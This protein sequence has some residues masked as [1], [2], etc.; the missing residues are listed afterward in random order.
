[1]E[2]IRE[3]YYM[4]EFKLISKLGIFIFIFSILTANL[5]RI[6]KKITDDPIFKNQLIQ[7]ESRYKSINKILIYGSS[8][9]LMG[10]SAETIEKNINIKSFNIS[11]TGFGGQTD[12]ALSSITSRSNLGDIILV[13]DR[14]YRT[15]I[16]KKSIIGNISIIP[17]LKIL[18]FPPLFK[19]N[20]HG[21]LEIYPEQPFMPIKNNLAPNYDENLIVEKMILQINIAKDSGLCPVL[22]LVPIL[23]N[24]NE[25]EDFELATNKIFSNAKFAGISQNLLFLT[26]IETNKDLFIDQFHMS[27]A[28][29][30]KWTNAVAFEM[31]ERNICDIKSY[32]NS[33]GR[34]N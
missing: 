8:A 25:K 17:E 2:Q 4:R 23:V 9:L 30:D 13:G 15:S 5:T 24:P 33:T 34:F 1:M 26:S 19:R 32:N 11:S 29:R 28:G 6:N 10:I 16:S 27:K 12:I 3:I 31:L 7:I 22:A 18:F 21:D 20:L 14:E